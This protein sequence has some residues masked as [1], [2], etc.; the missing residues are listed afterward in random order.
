MTEGKNMRSGLLLAL[1]FFACTASAEVCIENDTGVPEEAFFYQFVSAVQINNSRP[2]H[3]V[4]T[5]PTKF[6]PSHV[7]TREDACISYSR[8]AILG[9][10]GYLLIYL[11]PAAT[12]EAAYASESVVYVSNEPVSA[13]ASSTLMLAVE[14][15]AGDMIRVKS[16]L[17]G[18][19]FRKFA[20]KRVYLSDGK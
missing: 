6:D 11:R 5:S 7:D 16:K 13:A 10:P 4:L 8:T 15:S 20:M 2:S 17:D 12:S 1:I 9:T 19:A 14:S 18:G 3:P